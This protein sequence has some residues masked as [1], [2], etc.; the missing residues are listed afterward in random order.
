MGF[1]NG[2]GV[3][4]LCGWNDVFPAKKLTYQIVHRV[5]AMAGYRGHFGHN[6]ISQSIERKLKVETL[7]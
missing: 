4:T 2:E 7:K 1:R 5:V 6:E 3:L